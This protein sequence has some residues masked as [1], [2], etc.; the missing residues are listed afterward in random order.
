VAMSDELPPPPASK[1]RASQIAINFA[2]R[3]KHQIKDERKQWTA[4][5]KE[6]ASEAVRKVEKLVRSE[7]KKLTKDKEKGD[8][9]R[10]LRRYNAA[11][12]VKMAL[13]EHAHAEGRDGDSYRMA[14]ISDSI[15]LEDLLEVAR[16]RFARE[17]Q[18]QVLKLL[19]LNDEG[20]TVAIDSQRKLHQWL[21]SAWC[22]H[23]MALH[24]IDEA[25][26][27]TDALDLADR[28]SSL[29]EQY[30]DDGDGF[31]DEAELG[32]LLQ[33]MR[34]TELG[35]TEQMV[36]HFVA[37]EFAAADVD[38]SGKL[39]FDEFCRYYNKLSDWARK[40]LVSHN[41]HVHIYKTI[42]EHYLETSMAFAPLDRSDFTNYQGEGGTLVT[43]KYSIKVN[44]GPGALKAGAD[45][46]LAV[47]TLL[48]HRVSHLIDENNGAGEQGEY[49]FTPIVELR[50]KGMAAWLNCRPCQCLSSAPV[51][52]AWWLASP[53]AGLALRGG[54]AQPTGYL[55]HC[56]GCSSKLPPGSLIPPPLTIQAWRRTRTSCSPS[57]CCCR[58]PSTPRT[59]RSQ[60]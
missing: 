28:A 32:K 10:I 3:V 2:G 52:P 43:E 58:T 22:C 14:E 49:P 40:Q 15:R 59:A 42:S 36:G 5:D 39:D 7:D 54:R 50:C 13:H 51:P 9:D 38:G 16:H 44:V 56:R 19:W 55:G 53:L 60:W 6:L 4:L 31:I 30:D 46:K 8:A 24:V 37:Q 57:S 34:L 26:A 23:P 29:F 18:T 20:V 12:T 41:Q 17:G 25:T 45:A 47:G 21:D 48:S 35:V 33:S 1:T 27:T 11:V